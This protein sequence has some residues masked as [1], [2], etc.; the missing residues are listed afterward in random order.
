[1]FPRAA[2]VDAAASADAGVQATGRV[3][4]APALLPTPTPTDQAARVQQ[5]SI[6]M[7]ELMFLLGGRSESLSIS[8][9]VA[10]R[11][12]GGSGCVLDLLPK[13]SGKLPYGGLAALFTSRGP[14]SCC[15]IGI[16]QVG[17]V[18]GANG[19]SAPRT[20]H[21]RLRRRAAHLTE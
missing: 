21:R 11:R 17:G 7:R 1:M 10:C 5:A 14:L 16:S 12:R 13:G 20:A 2:G 15:P 9:D 19:C 8:I 6:Q 3:A 4:L 18:N